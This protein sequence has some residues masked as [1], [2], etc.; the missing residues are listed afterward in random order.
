MALVCLR[1][2]AVEK[3]ILCWKR[4]TQR[5]LSPSCSM[6]E[7]KDLLIRKAE[8]CTGGGVS[9]EKR[10]RYINSFIRHRKSLSEQRLISSGLY[11]EG[12]YVR[13]TNQ[14]NTL[15]YT[16]TESIIYVRN[17]SQNGSIYKWSIHHQLTGFEPQ[18]MQQQLRQSFQQP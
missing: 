13:M 12:A 3:L 7:E 4:G 14:V 6:T 2:H 10:V 17:S 18:N 9:Q 15:Q 16:I 5:A 8:V 11:L 1:E